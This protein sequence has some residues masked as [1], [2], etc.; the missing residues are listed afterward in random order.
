M[1]LIWLFLFNLEGCRKTKYKKRRGL[2][3]RC[4]TIIRQTKKSHTT[5]LV[6]VVIVNLEAKN[7]SNKK[8]LEL[9]YLIGC[10]TFECEGDLDTRVISG[11]S[12]VWVVVINGGESRRGLLQK[13]LPHF[14]RVFCVHLKA[15]ISR[16]WIIK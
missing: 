15:Q 1:K 9:V 6:S 14:L 13:K 16:D 4:K 8:S 12:S 3:C 7:T 10:I 2:I 11:R 5:W